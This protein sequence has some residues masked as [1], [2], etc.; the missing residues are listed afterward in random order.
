MLFIE[1]ARVESLDPI[2]RSNLFSSHLPHS[3]NSSQL[4]SI[5]KKGELKK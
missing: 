3:N 4:D 1:E 2:F 5:K